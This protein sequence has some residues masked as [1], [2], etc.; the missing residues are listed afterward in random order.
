MRPAAWE[1]TGSHSWAGRSLH[2]PDD[3]FASRA[4]SLYSQHKAAWHLD[5]IDALRAGR[6]PAPVH[7]QL[8]LSDLCN[9]DCL[10]AGTLIE[11]PDGQR[12]IEDIRVGDPVLGPDGK[13]V[14]VAEIGDRMADE[15]YEISVGG[16]VVRCTGEH[17]ILTIDGWREA[18]RLR[19]GDCAVVRVRMREVGD[20]SVTRI[21]R[22]IEEPLESQEE[23]ASSIGGDSEGVCVEGITLGRGMGFRPIDSIRLIPGKVRVF[24]FACP[25][26]EAYIANGVAVH[27]CN[28]CAYRMSSG[29]S[30]ELFGTAETHNPNR[31]IPTE[32]ALEIISDCA[33]IGVKAIQFTG[34]GEP[35]VHPDHLRIF[36]A[37]QDGGMKTAL[38]S[39]GVRL[40]AEADP[41]RAMTWVRI[42]VDAGTAATYAR[43][44][45][46]SEL[47]WQKAWRTVESLARH[48]AGAVGVGFVVTPDNYAEIAAAAALAKSSG[49]HNIRIGA[50][51]SELG[52]RFYGEEILARILDEVAKARELS[53]DGFEVIDLFG[54]RIG[55]LDGGSPSEPFCGYQY[56]T[57]YVAGDLGVYRCC[58]TAYTRAGKFADLTNMR[59]RDLFGGPI[60]P[61]DARSCRYCQFRGQNDAIAALT[62]EPAHAEFV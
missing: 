33:D 21:S 42:S 53:G 2:H 9:H 56:L 4:L 8:I 57:T 14:K 5:R 36:A 52:R 59:F 55:D 44:R 25:P 32:K 39:N 27:N 18:R 6:V 41:V 3:H 23:V 51:F 48:C 28:F 43:I 13:P 61:F 34:G 38:V 54:R 46:V 1:T 19:V 49:A 37:A 40:N 12:P 10:P 47:H 62:R 11:C 24:N 50:V 7:V 45:R 20:E 26:I 31:R 58:N 60:T 15:V 17:P 22:K 30:N 16:H 29:L 35:T